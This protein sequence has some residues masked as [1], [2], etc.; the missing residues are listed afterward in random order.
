VHVVVQVNGYFV[1]TSSN[2]RLGELRGAAERA[3][4]K[5]SAASA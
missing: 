5:L 1:I 3:F 4:T 2:G